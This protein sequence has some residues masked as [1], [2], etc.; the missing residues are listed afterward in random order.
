MTVRPGQQVEGLAVQPADAGVVHATIGHGRDV[1]HQDDAGPR[2]TMKECVE[3]VKEQ[4]HGAALL[5]ARQEAGHSVGPQEK[6][7]PRDC[8]MQ[9]ALRQ[10]K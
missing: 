8:R 6:A 9:P 1:V 3:R 10:P 7:R 2:G 5:P 4:G